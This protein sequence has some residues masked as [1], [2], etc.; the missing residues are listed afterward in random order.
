M[1]AEIFQTRSV[2]SDSKQGKGHNWSG[3]KPAKSSNL[4]AERS[5]LS[6]ILVPDLSTPE[7]KSPSPDKTA[8]HASPSGGGQRCTPPLRASP[9]LT[10]G[11]DTDAVLCCGESQLDDWTAHQARGHK[12]SVWPRENRGESTSCEPWA[13][14]TPRNNTNNLHSNSRE[15]KGVG[16]GGGGHFKLL[17]NFSCLT[18]KA[19]SQILKLY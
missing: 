16:G 7:S 3:N 17:L 13:A 4:R 11:G 8:A 19:E 10:G 5:D 18:L 1:S 2:S 15:G 14:A 9:T 12:I 6:D